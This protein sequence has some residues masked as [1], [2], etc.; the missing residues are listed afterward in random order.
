MRL[1]FLSPSGQ[2]GGAEA[3]L[4]SV[5]ASVRAAEPSWPLH[6]IIAGAGPMRAAVEELG[7]AAAVLPFPAALARLGEHGTRGARGGSVRLAA[8]AASAAPSLL[9]YVARL[10]NAIQAF[11]PRVIHTNGLKMHLLGAWTV[12]SIPLIW[13]LHDYLG[14]RPFTTRLLRWNASRCS[15]LI[16]NSH[17][18]ADD[19]RAALGDGPRIVAVYNG[20]DL[21]RFAPEGERADLDALAGLPCAGPGV[22]RVGLLGTFAR[23]KGHDVFLQAIARLPRELPVRAYVIGGPV[24][25]T[26]GSQYTT[27]EL[28]AAAQ[29]LGV[30]DRV[31]FTGFLDRADCAL[32]ALDVVVH[33]STMPEPFGL[34]IAE[35][36]ACGR[37]VVVSNAGGAAELAI[38]GTDALMHDPADAAALAA[39]IRRLVDDPSLRTRLGTSARQTAERAF[40]R[41]R[42][43]RELVPVYRSAAAAG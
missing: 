11:D 2:L 9:G 4:L 16:A 36:M 13:H 23:W 43:A 39:C 5:L 8:A 38:A 19:A 17:S 26:D 25:D 24:Y 32:R 31:G 30:A 10:R 7:V 35:A 34:V 6:V 29:A 37:A 18:V 42:L 41:S 28:R 22:V 1:M 15:A 40:D 33:A 14:P 21:T 12:R 27:G 20:V 3:S